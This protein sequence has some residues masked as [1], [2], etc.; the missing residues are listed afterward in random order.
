MGLIEVP[1]RSMGMALITE[2]IEM[3][4]LQGIFNIHLTIEDLKNNL[5]NAAGTRVILHFKKSPKQ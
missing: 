1:K 4:N 5:R 2:R 3:L